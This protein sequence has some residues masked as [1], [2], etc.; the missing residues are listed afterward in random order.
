MHG[1]LC[2]HDILALLVRLHQVLT[3]GVLVALAH[4]RRWRTR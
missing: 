4:F 2:P 3:S 1:D